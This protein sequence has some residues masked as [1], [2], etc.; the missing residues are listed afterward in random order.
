MMRM[1][2]FTSEKEMVCVCLFVCWQNN[3]KK[4]QMSKMARGKDDQISL[5]IHITISILEF[6]KNRFFIIT[7]ISHSMC[8]GP[9]GEVA[10]FA[11]GNSSFI[12]C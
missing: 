9:H 12:Y 4:R 11:E 8:I 7:L 1:I 2:L 5:V 3:L 10:T 6:M